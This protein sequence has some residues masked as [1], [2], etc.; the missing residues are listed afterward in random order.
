MNS[1][2]NRI[3][4][5]RSERDLTMCW[6]MFAVRGGLSI[7]FAVVLF[8]TSSFLG[9]FFFDPVALTYLSLLLGSY[10]L[11]N[12][13]LLAVAAFFAFEH[14]LHVWWLVLG[15]SCFALL[16]GVYIGIS[17]VLTPQ[18]LAFLA[19]LNAAGTGCFQLALG[20]KVREDRPKLVLLGTAGIVSLCAGALF[21]THY[22][23]APRVTTQ[24]LSGFELFGGAIWMIF[25]FRLHR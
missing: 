5:Q 4:I 10:V 17:L 11:G 25:A 16:L 3:E 7:V 20:I 23:Q 1:I 8:L 9:I 19:G 22:N 24:L 18:S 21:L 14:H 2:S 13:L 15:E 12:G 6:W